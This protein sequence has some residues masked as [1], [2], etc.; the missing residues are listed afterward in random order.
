M[1]ADTVSSPV[2]HIPKSSEMI[3][4]PC[5][6]C[7]VTVDIYRHRKFVFGVQ[8]TN[9]QTGPRL[10]GVSITTWFAEPRKVTTTIAHFYY[11]MKSSL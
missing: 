11:V 9:A 4:S 7:G 6:H 8:I 2:R 3:N 10:T 1:L 5:K